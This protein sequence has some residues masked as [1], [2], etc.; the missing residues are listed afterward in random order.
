MSLLSGRVEESIWPLNP[1]EGLS[2]TKQLMCLSLVHVEL[3]RERERE[4]ARNGEGIDLYMHLPKPVLV[5]VVR[6]NSK[7]TNTGSQVDYI[8][9]T[10]SP[11]LSLSLCVSFSSS[12]QGKQCPSMSSSRIYQ[13]KLQLDSLP[14]FEY[15]FACLCCSEPSSQGKSNVRTGTCSHSERCK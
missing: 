5:S 12:H 14:L 4:K 15:I 2:A 10:F 8:L 3:E 13:C 11:S 9:I 6:V 1:P 7:S